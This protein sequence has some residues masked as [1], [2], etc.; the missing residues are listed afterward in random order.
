MLIELGDFC[1]DA[2]VF[3]CLGIEGA[4][5]S[6]V[7]EL[8]CAPIAGVSRRNSFSAKSS[9]KCNTV[10]TLFASTAFGRLEVTAFD[11]PEL[12]RICADAAMI[13]CTPQVER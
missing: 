5:A 8:A 4:D 6:V 13:F 12:V 10:D 3:F 7:T 2:G 9:A 11:A 1:F